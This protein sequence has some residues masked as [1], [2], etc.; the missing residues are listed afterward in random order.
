MVIYL[1]LDFFNKSQESAASGTESLPGIQ[2]GSP[3]EE[4][5]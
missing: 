4:G 3:W 5:S 1:F 2:K